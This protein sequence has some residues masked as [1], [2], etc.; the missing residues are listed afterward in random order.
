MSYYSILFISLF[1]GINTV[2]GQSTV[3]IIGTIDQMETGTAFLESQTCL[4]PLF[5]KTRRCR[6]R[7]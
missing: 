1:L 4:R 2:F 5:S 7:I 6:L 3:R